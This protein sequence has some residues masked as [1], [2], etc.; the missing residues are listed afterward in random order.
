MPQ[1]EA[2]KYTQTCRPPTPLPPGE[3]RGEGNWLTAKRLPRLGRAS[4]C[5][6]KILQVEMRGHLT[7]IAKRRRVA[8]FRGPCRVLQ[9]AWLL[10]GRESMPPVGAA[11]EAVATGFQPVGTG[12]LKTRRHTIRAATSKFLFGDLVPERTLRMTRAGSNQFRFRP[13]AVPVAGGG[14]TVDHALSEMGQMLIGTSL[15]IEGFLQQIRSFLVPHLP[16]PG[17][18]SHR[19]RS[20]NVRLSEQ[21][22]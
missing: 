14:F 2:G 4:S 5:P 15:F 12:K 21:R 8:C 17:T 22:Q 11:N 13:A 10:K 1:H 6:A 16:G 18:R 20:R 7:A 19:K 3:G 9:S